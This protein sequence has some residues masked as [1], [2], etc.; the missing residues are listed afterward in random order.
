M[1]SASLFSGRPDPT[2]PVEEMRVRELEA[3]WG[4]F[5]PWTGRLPEPPPLGYRHCSLRCPDGR[6][7][8]AYA[9]AV[10]LRANGRSE[11]RT[12]PKRQFERMLLAS[13]P[14]GTLPP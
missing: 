12:D 2:W 5:A 1:G 3:L 8:T 14:P 7:W 13:A 6:E 10:T 9:G 4:S 11:S